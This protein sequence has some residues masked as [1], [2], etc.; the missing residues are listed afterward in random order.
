VDIVSAVSPR[1]DLDPGARAGVRRW[2][3]PA[4]S[5]ARDG[6][7][8]QAIPASA[9]PASATPT[10]AARA[11]RAGHQ[12]GRL[13]L[14]GAPQVLLQFGLARTTQATAR[15]PPAEAD[16]AVSAQEVHARRTAWCYWCT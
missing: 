12:R 5:T 10:P 13:A 4:G 8:A 2:S 16:G 9:T 14:P 11:A 1:Q 15:R 7:P 6:V 3:R